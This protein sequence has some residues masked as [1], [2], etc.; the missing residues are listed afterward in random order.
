MTEVTKLS[1]SLQT[2]VLEALKKEAKTLNR[3]VLDHLRIELTDRAIAS[4]HLEKSEEEKLKLFRE[5]CGGVAREALDICKRGDF[6]PD[7]T[8]QAIKNCQSRSDSSWLSSYSKYIDGDIFGKDNPRKKFLNQSIGYSVIMAI[9]G[10]R[11]IGKNGKPVV[12]KVTGEIIKSYTR[13]DGFEI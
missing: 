11:R 2:S 1:L 9:K 8:L 7:I 4:G 3:E 5:V 6:T 12:V 13:I 10:K